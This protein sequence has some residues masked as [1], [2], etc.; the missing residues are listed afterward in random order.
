MKQ[1]PDIKK[2]SQDNSTSTTLYA[3]Y[4]LALIMSVVIIVK[5][6]II[7][8]TYEVPKKL[9]KYFVPRSRKQ[10][11]KP[12]RG[13]ILS[14]DGRL[15]AISTPLY[16]IFM[17]CTVRKDAFAADTKRGKER[18]TEWQAKARDLAA[19][20]SEI[21]KDKT[22]TQ[23][24]DLIMTSRRNGKKHVAIGGLIDHETLKK[25]QALPLFEEGGFKGGIIVEQRETRQYPYGALARRTIGYVTD[26]SDRVNRIGIEG[27]F[28][29]ELHGREGYEWLR[30][31]DERR[32]VPNYDSTSV[33]ARNGLDIRTTLNIDYQDIAD[34]ALRNQIADEPKIQSACAIIMDV[35]TGAIRAMVNLQ[36]DS[37][38][39]SPLR[40]RI[41]LAI[42]QVGE[43]G[44]VFKTVTLMSLLEDGYIR[45]LEDI[46]PT[47]H[48][49]IGKEY[50]SDQ[51][52]RDYEYREKHNY[53]SIRKGF[54]ISSNYVFAHL[55]LKYYGSHP[56][57]FFDKIYSY[58]LG[59]AFDF[60][61]D[62]LG[63]P[64]V[65]SPSSPYWSG[66]TLGTTAYGYSISVTPLH[67]AT[68]Y[69]AIANKGKMMKPYLVESIEKNGVVQKKFN[70]TVLNSICS[71]ATAD[72]L[73]RAL[74]SVTTNKGATGTR[75]LGK[76]KAVVAGKTGTARI[77]LSPSERPL[78]G[79]GYQ[80][81]QGRKKN[82]GTFVGFFPAEDPK[83]TV[84]VTVYSTLSLTSFYGGTTPALVVREIVD[85]IYALD[86][87]WSD[88]IPRQAS[89]QKMEAPRNGGLYEQGKT[90][91][92]KG[93]GLKDAIK[94][95]ETSGF[96]CS[97]SGSG[98]VISQ[99]P[100]PGSDIKAGDIIT[101]MLR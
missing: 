5:I 66:S 40:E 92:V 51:H 59:E 8:S 100:A 53:I 67:V 38:A 82:Q 63:T 74:A 69:N 32:E 41:N 15:L 56:Q 27:R 50:P 62:G 99:V 33:K 79:N 84:L 85:N 22:A 19:G 23:Y 49:F 96:K 37:T 44:S 9:E 83:Y 30:Q 47:N 4:I 94:E 68:F 12:N 39:G 91:D 77:A 98:H 58:K 81:A 2:S 24:Y 10:V 34:R 7:Q 36:R 43:Q 45:S 60:D 29:Y 42:G 14:T 61:I 1:A 86:E 97:W 28:D 80:D 101:L 13:A 70:P 17:D 93:L 16:Q 71:K 11:T 90:P 73:T 76:A 3:I 35:K 46:I 95:I 87:Q 20:L 78:K 52:I 31:S 64:Q 57:D 65:I 72:T 54:E 48:G 88:Q 26:N 6:V 25:V 55:A 21:Y 75:N 89:V 18:E